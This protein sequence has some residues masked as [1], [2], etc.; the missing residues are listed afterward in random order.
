MKI[1][2]LYIAIGKYKVF[3]K[4]FF[5]SSES[6]FI[7]E[8]DKHYF[9]FTDS[10]ELYAMENE[11]VF[12]VKQKDLGWPK[13]TLLRFAMFDSIRNQLSKFD[14]LFFFNA[15]LVILK[16]ITTDF[17]PKDEN[18]LVALHP[19]YYLEKE[20]DRYPYCRNPKSKA[21]IAYG[22]GRYYAQGALNGGKTEAFL[23]LIEKLKM[24]TEEDLKRGIIA[25]VHDESHLN[26][27]ILNRDDVKIVGPQYI[28]PEGWILNEEPII[29]SR[30]KEKYFN[31]DELKK[32]KMGYVIKRFKRYV[33]IWIK[34]GRFYE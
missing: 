13:N 34:G 23:K 24:A 32:G 33:K 15:N 27:Y 25:D 21:Y 18:L 26:H 2:V 28:Y 12:I 20:V 10:E 29:L 14:Y 9:V 4:D 1:G 5:L 19:S 17:L 22:K 16:E 8:I 6:L 7:K 31:V 30:D 3:W 11:K